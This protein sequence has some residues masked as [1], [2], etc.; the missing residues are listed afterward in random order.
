MKSFL[1][2]VTWGWALLAGIIAR[3][4]SADAVPSSG[5]ADVAADVAARVAVT[6][7]APWAAIP[8]QILGT[9][10][11]WLKW[12]WTHPVARVVALIAV[13]FVWGWISGLRHVNTEYEALIKANKQIVAQATERAKAADFARAAAE[14]REAEAIASATT[15]RKTVNR[16]LGLVD[17][18]IDGADA[19]P[20][21]APAAAPVK[22]VVPGPIPAAASR[23]VHH[24]KRPAKAATPR[25][26]IRSRLAEP[27]AADIVRAAM[28]GA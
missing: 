13:A 3:K 9:V 7:A 22:P 25:P 14:K 8:M 15:H 27:T 18:S 19:V 11:D 20:Q 28:G 10:W 21:P 26:P 4:P 17:G 12:V 24:V 23:A 2:W 16:I 5:L 1:A 6:A